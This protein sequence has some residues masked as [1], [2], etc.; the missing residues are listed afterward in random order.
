M[1]EQCNSIRQTKS[2][3]TNS[4]LTQFTGGIDTEKDETG[5]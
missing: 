2:V 1:A 4:P 5:N 3:L